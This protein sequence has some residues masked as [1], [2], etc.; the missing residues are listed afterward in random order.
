L[1]FVSVIPTSSL[2]AGIVATGGRVV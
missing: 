2:T 1:G